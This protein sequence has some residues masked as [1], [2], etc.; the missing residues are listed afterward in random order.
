LNINPDIIDSSSVVFTL[1]EN[2]WLSYDSPLESMYS[3]P[4]DGQVDIAVTRV[5]NASTDGLGIIGTL[6]F[7]I[8]DELEGF[9]RSQLLNNSSLVKM[10]NIISTNAFG[11]Y[12]SHP[13]YEDVIKFNV[14]E[15][16]LEEELSLSVSITPNP[17][18]GFVRIESETYSIDRIEILDAL[19]R[20]V[21]SQDK[22][23]SRF[24]DLD[25]SSLQQGVYFV[26]IT[27]NGTTTV[28]KLEKID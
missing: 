3:V 6:E 21:F 24:H 19:G 15:E 14:E 28:K 8:E 16:D 11:E 20:N 23:T 5:S 18:A 22:S 26:R 4:Q 2:N 12:V 17:T 9:K 25:I 7:I 27:S 10:N 1:N 13:I